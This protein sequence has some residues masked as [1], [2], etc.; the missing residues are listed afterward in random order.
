[1]LKYNIRIREEIRLGKLPEG[2]VN[3]ELETH[4]HRACVL[5]IIFKLFPEIKRKK[6]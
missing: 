2:V 3:A 5:E 6:K 1:M 4:T